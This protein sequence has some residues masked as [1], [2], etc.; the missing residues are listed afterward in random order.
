MTSICYTPF[1]IPK[2]RV[3]QLNSCGAAVTGCTFAVT[4]GIISIALTKEYEARQE[5]F[6]KNGNGDFCVRET[7]APILKWIN[8]VA[9]FCN[10]DPEMYNIMSAEPLYLNDAVSPVAI[11]YSTQE[12]T[13]AAANFALE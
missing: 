4:D 1:K 9:T 7:N 3:T 6:V 11:G 8:I 12:G 10:V 5:F 2:V 13:A